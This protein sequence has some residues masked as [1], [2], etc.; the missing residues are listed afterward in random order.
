M[1][2]QVKCWTNASNEDLFF[3]GKLFFV[4]FGNIGKMSALFAD[5][6]AVSD[7]SALGYFEAV[8]G[9]GHIDQLLIRIK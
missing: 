3:S 7:Q 5:I 8:I 4:N 1:N 2:L 6:H 9:Y